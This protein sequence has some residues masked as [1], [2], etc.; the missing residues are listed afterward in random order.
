MWLE[1]LNIFPIEYIVLLDKHSER[2]IHELIREL[3]GLKIDIDRF[4]IL[5][6]GSIEDYYPIEI[7]VKAL[8]ELFGIE[9]KEEDIA[10]SKPRDKEIERILQ[11]HDKMRRRWKI[12]I[13]EYVASQLSKEQIP[14]EIKMAFERVKE[15]VSFLPSE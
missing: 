1:L 7:V 15:K 11:E 4:L 14:K 12:D 8:K 9:V 5:N 6:K 13:G 2:L 3:R 10:S